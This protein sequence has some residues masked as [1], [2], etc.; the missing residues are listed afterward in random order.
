[1]HQNLIIQKILLFSYVLIDLLLFSSIILIFLILDI[2][3]ILSFIIFIPLFILVLIFEY[4]LQE[5]KIIKYQINLLLLFLYSL[6]INLSNKKSL[7]KSINNALKINENK[8]KNNEISYTFMKIEKEL[9]FHDIANSIES[10]NENK[11]IKNQIYP[12]N[13][14]LSDILEDIADEYKSNLNINRA[15]KTIYKRLYNN[16]IGQQNKDAAFIKKFFTLSIVFTTVV[17]SILLFGF[18]AY[19]MIFYSY[20]EFEIFSFL[21][22]GF[23]PSM[24]MV[25]QMYISESYE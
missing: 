19:S 11:K 15:V 14:D 5:K 13:F 4:Y 7:Y 22:V 18:I 17:P 10:I 23:V 8:I 25:I 12:T 20:F 2:N 24:Y 21:L 9:K 1:M 6:H 16:K 3:L